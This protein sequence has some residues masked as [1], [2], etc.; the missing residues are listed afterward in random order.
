MD[1]VNKNIK[2]VHFTGPGKTIHEHNQ[3]FIKEYWK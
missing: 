3:S 2:V 1:S